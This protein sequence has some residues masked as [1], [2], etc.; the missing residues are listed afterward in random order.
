[1]WMRRVDQVDALIVADALGVD[2]LR[3]RRNGTRRASGLTPARD[4][5]S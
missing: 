3:Y 1:M 5:I 2:G 4:R